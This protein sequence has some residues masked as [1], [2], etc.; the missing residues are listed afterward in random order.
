MVKSEP[1]AVGDVL[2]NKYEVV[3]K[4][5]AGSMGVV[6]EGRHRALN[7][8]VAIKTLH[9]EVAQNDDLVG[10]FEQEARRASALG[11]PNIVEVFDL[12]SAPN[13][14]RFMVM[15]HLNGETLGEYLQRTPLTT[16]HR[17]GHIVAEVLSALSAAHRRGIV[18]R[19]LKPDNI[20]LARTDAAPERVK[21]LDFGISKVMEAADPALAAGSKL[22]KATRLGT[23][24]GTPL[25]MAPEQARGQPDVDH[26]CDLWAV[27]CVLYEML[28]GRTPFQGENY[29]QILTAIVVGEFP[30]PRSL[31]PSLPAAAEEFLVKSLANDRNRRFLSAENMRDKLIATLANSGDGAQPA[32]EPALAVGSNAFPKELTKPGAPTQ[33]LKPP[34]QL[35]DTSPDEQALASALDKL[36]APDLDPALLT[37]TLDDNAPTPAPETAAL[38]LAPVTVAA[39]PAIDQQVDA[40]LF[41][42]PAEEEFDSATLTV[43]PEVLQEQRAQPVMAPQVSEVRKRTFSPT[44]PSS[45]VSSILKWFVVII[46]VGASGALGYRYYKKGAFLPADKPTTTSVHFELSPKDALIELNGAPLTERPFMAELGDRYEI[47]IRARGRLSAA[48][49]IQPAEGTKPRIT[50]ALP[51]QLGSLDVQALGAKTAPADPPNGSIDAALVKLGIYWQCLSPLANTLRS[52][53][54]AY[55]RTARSARSIGKKRIPTVVQ[56]PVDVVSRCRLDLSTAVDRKPTMATIDK[57]VTPYFR[58]LDELLS[59]TQRLH[60]YYKEEEY[61]Q[62]SFKL[63]KTQHRALVA[64]LR[65]TTKEHNRLLATVATARLAWHLRDAERIKK[66]EG[67]RT[68]WHF[69][70]LVLAATTLITSMARGSVT[71]IRAARKRLQDAYSAAIAHVKTA[72][73]ETIK[74][75]GAL[76][77]AAKEFVEFSTKLKETTPAAVLTQGVALHNRCVEQFNAL[78]LRVRPVPG[79][80]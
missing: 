21:L 6:F 24:L 77:R 31:R 43:S 30:L 5:G 76:L 11:H 48:G 75:G 56:L 78:V 14:A 26:R 35:A 50:I 1:I 46:V 52:A 44:R 8:R 62:D 59:I 29:N 16:P 49:T 68:H 61:K 34:E 79:P 67:E 13:G 64:A 47:S 17:A 74:G 40:D 7:K 19:D 39:A 33:S 72:Q 27:G 3:A 37:G 73:A 15:E 66:T 69:R 12:G 9:A 45:P 53:Q 38:S 18:H 65:A 2:D 58:H 57:G 60:R 10:R 20:F 23:V 70:N 54:D 80:P 41:A 22:A 25:Y 63:G 42:P 71:S 51:H 32:P 55:V 28:C 4:L 36:S